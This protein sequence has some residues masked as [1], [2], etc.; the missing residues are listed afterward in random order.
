MN[1]NILYLLLAVFAFLFNPQLTRAQ[2]EGDRINTSDTSVKKN[3]MDIDTYTDTNQWD[4]K[5][6]L[7]GWDYSGGGI[8]E[9]N[10]DYLNFGNKN[11][12]RLY[13][14][15]NKYLYSL[16]VLRKAGE[17]ADE[18][19]ILCG[20]YYSKCLCAA[21]LRKTT[22][23]DYWEEILFDET[24]YPF[25]SNI[26]CIETNVPNSQDMSDYSRVFLGCSNGSIF[27]SDNKGLTFKKSI[28]Y[29]DNE[30][31]KRIQFYNENTGLALSGNNDF[32]NTKLYKTT[33]GGI[34]WYL[35]RD[36]Q[37]ENIV[38]YDLHIT[39]H[40]NSWRD[41]KNITLLSGSRYKQ[42]IVKASIDYGETFVD[43]EI[44]L[45]NSDSTQLPSPIVSVSVFPESLNSEENFI[46]MDDSGIIGYSQGEY[47]SPLYFPYNS[48]ENFG[49]GKMSK[50]INHPKAK[51]SPMIGI[52]YN[53]LIYQFLINWPVNVEEENN[54]SDII[55]IYDNNSNILTISLKNLIKPDFNKISIF[56][57]LGEK[58]IESADISSEKIEIQLPALTR[59]LYFF[60]FV[61]PRTQKSGKFLIL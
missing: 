20:G 35:L 4:H 33:D 50:V 43:K 55:Y 41:I 56:N 30:S 14:D 42:G 7:T 16:K 3:F 5:W 9:F 19:V 15:K 10:Q 39:T 51:P 28:I 18:K 58:I 24:T 31:I 40:I 27:Y 46:A 12:T 34:Y 54:F 13:E 8:Y 45:Y 48:Y 2:N 23:N 59:G 38:L 22:Q 26:Y 21:L 25:I 49:I 32:E 17:S 11:L 60:Y 36:F 47:S 37:N 57:I 52:G 29:A 6:I 44:I 1:K 61:G 53:G